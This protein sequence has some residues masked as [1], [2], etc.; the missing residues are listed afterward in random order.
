MEKEIKIVKP[1]TDAT[2]L[3]RALKFAITEGHAVMLADA[4]E[5]FDPVISPVLGK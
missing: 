1:T 2:T 3:M 4:N 5:E